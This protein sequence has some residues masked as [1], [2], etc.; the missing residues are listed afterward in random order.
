MTRR[1]RFLSADLPRRLLRWAVIA[2]ALIWLALTA[3]T[4]CGETIYVDS[5]LGEDRFDGLSQQ[6]ASESTGPVKTLH[7]AVQLAG[8]GDVIVLAVSRAPYYG[9]FSLVGDQHSGFESRPFEIDGN[10]AI[11]SGAKPVSGEAWQLA[12]ADVWRVTPVRKAFYQLILNGQAVPEAPCPRDAAQLPEL[13]TRHWCAWRG[14]VYYRAEHSDDPRRMNFALADEEVGLTLLD[15]HD[16]VIRNVTLRHY[17]LDGI[18]AHDRCRNVV[19]DRVTCEQ[20]GRAGIAVSGTSRVAVLG[21]RVVDNRG[22][23]LLLT[24]NGAAYVENSNLDQPATLPGK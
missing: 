18:N 13:P 20:N 22:H 3:R 21:S 19:L 24:E 4:V 10:G 23:S 12:A 16:V 6:V 11:L 1:P 7:R 14:A 2:L 9:S 5:R 8:A 15:V 17:R